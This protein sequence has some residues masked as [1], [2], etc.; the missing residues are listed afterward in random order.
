MFVLGHVG[1]S[2]GIV[3]ALVLYYN[4]Y[5][6]KR[7]T[8]GSL[9][10]KIDFRI[11]AISAMT[12]D[13]VDKIIGMWILGDEVSNGRIFTHSLITVTILSI[14][15]VNLSKIKFSQT[16]IPLLYVFPVFLHL[17][18]DGLWELPGTLFWP[19]M[20]TRF[21]RVDVEFGD[22]FELLL[23]SP[24]AYMGEIIGSTI[25]ILIFIKYRLFIKENFVRFFERGHLV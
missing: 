22:Y 18:L 11:I 14:A 15:I 16:S 21:P 20:G 7:K 23:S 6:A 1:I 13:I 10:G 25:I 12:P 17:V 5:I 24:V 4:N 3:L 8:G 2:L 9:L 19:L